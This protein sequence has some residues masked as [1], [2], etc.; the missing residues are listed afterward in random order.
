MRLHRSLLSFFFILSMLGLAPG[1]VSARLD[2]EISS[3]YSSSMIDPI[4]DGV[5]AKE[6]LEL[7]RHTPAR[8]QQSLVVL[9]TDDAYVDSRYPSENYGKEPY[10]LVGYKAVPFGFQGSLLQ[11]DLSDLPGDAI[12]EQAILY[13][14]VEDGAGADSID[15]DLHPLEAKWN[16]SDVTF[17]NAPDPGPVHTTAKG[18]GNAGWID[19]EVTGLVEEW[20]SGARNNHGMVLIGPMEGDY[21]RLFATKENAHTKHHPYLEVSYTVPIPV[22]PPTGSIHITEIPIEIHRR[23]AQHLE[24]VRGTEMAPGWEDATL[25]EWVRPLYRPDDLQA[26]G[27]WEIGIWPSDEL[28]E[29]AVEPGDNLRGFIVL[30]ANEH[31]FPI[32]HWG[33]AG[34]PPTYLLEE[35]ESRTGYPPEVFYKLDTLSYVAEDWSDSLVAIL[36]DLPP[37]LQGMEMDWL[38]EDPEITKTG[39]AFDEPPG[40]DDDDGSITGT[41]V[42]TG[43]VD[44]PPGLE[45]S[46]WDSWENL[47]AGY[48]DSYA[49]VMEDQRRRASGLWE[50]EQLDH[51]SGIVLRKNQ[52]YNMALLWDPD[53]LVVEGPGV[54]YI[55]TQIIPRDGFVAD[56]FEI[57]VASTV[58]MG[59]TPFTVTVT[60]D[61]DIQGGNIEETVR[62]QIVE[63]AQINL[64]L[65]TAGHAG[66]HG[67]ASVT[68]VGSTESAPE[69][70]AASWSGWRTFY[71]GTE[72]DQH[73]YLQIPAGQGPNDSNCASG[74]GATAWAML[75]G[76]ADNQAWEKHP[77]WEPRWGIYREDGLPRPAPDARAPDSMDTEEFGC[78]ISNITW[79]IREAVKTYCAPWPFTGSAA[80]NPWRMKRANDYL[81]SRTAARAHTE[82]SRKGSR[83]DEFRIT[84]AQSIIYGTPAII[85]TGW[86]SHYPLAFGYR[87][88]SRESCGLFR[89]STEYQHEFYVNQGWGSSTQNSWVPGE[90]WFVGEL[91]P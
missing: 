4:H 90:T 74:C 80:T 51:E 88:R 43:P 86:L 12:I 77:R 54:D 5:S 7:V 56:L 15:V 22:P 81:I 23:A 25:F 73:Y 84:A 6:S 32:A 47:K 69:T 57:A 13:A 61:G 14:Q 79:E 10:M 62:F 45:I 40:D 2:A 68:S 49:V 64:P 83:R 72:E 87:M 26:P 17:A 29:T 28:R 24:E 20:V 8:L 44:P 37:R 34:L 65:V 18:V 63:L 31:D 41:L 19:W 75:F 85:G 11:F 16:E 27:W 82:Y 76:W 53:E 1:S 55:T 66:D 70:V 3:G 50:A 30:S 52:V 60:Y 39:W 91:Y 38:D 89:C 48:A 33:S 78:G 35:E 42:I 59:F 67:S 58:P 71:A 21:V 9:P 46:G 36:G